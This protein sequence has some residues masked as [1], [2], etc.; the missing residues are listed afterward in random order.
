MSELSPQRWAYLKRLRPAP[1]RY[2]HISCHYVP[3]PAATIAA[4]Q[5]K[6]YFGPQHILT[7]GTTYDVGRNK[8]KRAK[9]AA[10]KQ[11]RLQLSKLTQQAAQQRDRLVAAARCQR[12]Q[13]N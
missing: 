7:T 9:R 13:W 2:L 8:A 10:A 6:S 5:N 12:G 3:H 11:R 1:P 4:A